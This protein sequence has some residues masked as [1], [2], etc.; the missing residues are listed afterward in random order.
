[1]ISRKLFSKLLA[2][3]V[4]CI[5]IYIA[6]SSNKSATFTINGSA[7]GT[8]WSVTSTE[9]IADHHEKNIQKIID[10]VDMV[11][12]NYKV[13]SE[14]AILNQKPINAPITISS[15]LYN[16][17]DIAKN[18]HSLS[19]GSYDITLGKISSELGFS[20]SFNKDLT[21]NQFSNYTLLDKDELIVIKSS[22]NWF[23][24]S[25]IA[26]GYAVQLIHNYLVSNNL[27]N[28]LI[29]IGGELI[30]NGTNNNQP[31]KIGI[32]N[33]ASLSDDAIYVVQ[34]N[35]NFLAIATSGEY[36]NY[37]ISSD[38]VKI[39]HT[40]NPKTLT[41]IKS[42]A[43]SVTVVHK[44]SATYADALATAFNV[45]GYPESIEYANKN[46]IALMLVVEID[47]EFKLMFSDEWY[48]LGL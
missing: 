11:A 2:L 38:N 25:S 17:L 10:N 43:L 24:L 28:H 47:N 46:N 4:G 19:D 36:R 13:N 31:W 45:I 35:N 5:C 21:Q 8:Y 6:Y 9:F 1:M 42:K 7:Y 27:S 12:S 14:V 40:I 3:I 16:I 32:Q 39:T 33:P 22:D 30:I 34:N 48:N 29:D 23:D 41:S 44:N 15:D 37:K 26:K 18:I 20:P